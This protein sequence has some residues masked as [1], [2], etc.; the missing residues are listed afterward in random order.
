MTL[1]V[2]ILHLH[3]HVLSCYLIFRF[4]R[5][6]FYYLLFICHSD[7]VILC[8]IIIDYRIKGTLGITGLLLFGVL[9]CRVVWHLDVDSSHPRGEASSKGWTV[10][11]LKWYVSWVQN[12]VKQF[13]C[14]LLCLKWTIN[15]FLLVRKE[16]KK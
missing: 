3:F 16:Q 4:N 2:L 12:V 15:F 10:R 11:S 9:I 6:L 1:F 7:P 5:K 14:Y 8:G 13:G